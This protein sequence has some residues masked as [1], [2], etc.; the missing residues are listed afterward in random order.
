[1]LLN[2]SRRVGHFEHNF[3]MEEGVTVGVRVIAI[4]CGIK[5]I[6]SALFGGHKACMWQTEEN[7]DS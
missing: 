7:Y 1:M 3:Q 4:S 2:T 5:N 6:C